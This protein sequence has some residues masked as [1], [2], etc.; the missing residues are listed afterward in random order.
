MFIAPLREVGS[1]RDRL[2]GADSDGSETAI[3][4]PQTIVALSNVF[5][6][7]NANVHPQFPAEGFQQH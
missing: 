7:P 6:S 1:G 2:R 3:S 5:P 4:L